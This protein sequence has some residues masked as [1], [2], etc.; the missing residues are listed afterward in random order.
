MKT[1][2]IW[3]LIEEYDG[4]TDVHRDFGSDM[5]MI[6]AFGTFEAAKQFLVSLPIDRNGSPSPEALGEE[7]RP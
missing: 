7:E 3:G 5:E 1:Y 2:T 4:E 6:G